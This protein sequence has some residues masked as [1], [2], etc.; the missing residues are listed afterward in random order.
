MNKILER[1][2]TTYGGRDGVVKDT[3]SGLVVHLSKPAEMG[4]DDDKGS[5]PEELFSIGYSSCFASSLEYLLHVAKIDY[6]GLS[7]QATTHLNAD[8]KTGFSF[9]LFVKA[10][11]EGVTKDVEKKFIEQA[12][13]FCPYSKAIKGNVVVTFVD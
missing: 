2:A 1:Q 5:N 3:Q 9:E 7:V 10:N 6:Q 11:I 12:Y 8:P 13:Q 4:G